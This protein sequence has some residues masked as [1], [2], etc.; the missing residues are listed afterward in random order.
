MIRRPPRS[1]HCISS[2]ASDV[3]KRQV[4]GVLKM[5]M[6]QYPI[7]ILP[8]IKQSFIIM[9]D[10]YKIL[11]KDVRFIEGLNACI[12]CGTCTAICPAA[13]FYDYDPREIVNIVQ[14]EDNLKIEELLKNNVI[15]Y[16]GECLSCKTR[17]PRNN[18]PGF[19]IMAL[20]SL[21]QDLG[22]FY[23]KRKRQTAACSKKNCWR[24]YFKTRILYV[25]R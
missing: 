8:L 24:M 18:T 1:T 13:E 17:C 10:Y 21:S 11:S 6:I 12:N 19:I 14:S 20:R 23:R 2:A 9:D 25:R 15:W 7:L 4:H 16:C 22:F 5:L 3:Y